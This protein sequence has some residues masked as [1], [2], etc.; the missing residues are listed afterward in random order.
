VLQGEQ[1]EEIIAKVKAEVK[2]SNQ[3]SDKS[4]WRA[5]ESSSQLRRK[6]TVVT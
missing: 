4:M 1:A 5:S 3:R 6:D 2:E